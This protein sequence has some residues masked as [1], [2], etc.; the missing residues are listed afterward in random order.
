VLFTAAFGL[1]VAAPPAAH[2]VS[3]GAPAL[4]EFVRRGGGLAVAHHRDQ[5]VD[6]LRAAVGPAPIRAGTW[7]VV[8]TGAVS[9][10]SPIP[11]GVRQSL[12]LE[13]LAADA[14]DTRL[15]GLRLVVDSDYSVFR[16]DRE[17]RRFETTVHVG[18]LDTIAGASA[19]LGRPVLVQITGSE[20]ALA[21]PM[22]LFLDH[23]GPPFVA[24]RLADPAPRPRTRLRLRTELDG[25]SYDLGIPFEEPV[26]VSVS[27]ERLQGFG[28]ESAEV[29]VEGPAWAD[30]TPVRLRAGRAVITPSVV[31]LKDGVARATVI[32]RFTGPDSVTAS[33]ALLATRS[34]QLRAEWPVAFL[35]WALAGALAGGGLATMR[36]RRARR[37]T[38]VRFAA[39][40]IAGLVVAALGLAGV[41]FVSIALRSEV[42]V[43]ALAA[44]GGY[45]GPRA[46]ER[47]APPPPAPDAP[48]RRTARPRS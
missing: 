14:A 43:F 48:V 26:R 12:P 40:A 25:R 5:G 27:R 21:E 11:G 15:L 47:F 46:L 4:R 37:S 29:V 41:Q 7:L 28:F 2:A 9:T 18:L 30:S 35:T 20:A 45:L 38:K 6:T 36:A 44:L 42:A 1:A 13:V 32:S 31:M 16:Y 22:E 19:P 34:A 23:A 33:G 3:V 8:T 24:V 10:E 39:A 17:A